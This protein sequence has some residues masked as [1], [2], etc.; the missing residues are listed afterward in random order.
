MSA[1]RGRLPEDKADATY[2]E[3]AKTIA[4][5]E[6]DRARRVLDYFKM[7][8]DKPVPE[9]ESMALAIVERSVILPAST[10]RQLE[11]L[12]EREGQTNWGD[13]ITRLIERSPLVTQGASYLGTEGR[14]F[15]NPAQEELPLDFEQEQEEEADTGPSGQT[16]RPLQLAEG[17]ESVQLKN[18]VIW[19]LKHYGVNA[20]FYTTGYAGKDIN[21]FIEILKAADIS[22]V[23]D[24]RHTPVSQYKPDFSREKLKAHLE[25]NGIEYIHKGD[26]GVPHE[27]RARAV[28]QETRDSIWDWYDQTVVPKISNGA[29]S[30][31]RES[32]KLP[33]AF[34]CVEM[35]PTL[36]H[37]HRL[38]QALKKSGLRGFDL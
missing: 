4:P 17:P 8:P 36:C 10:A 26:W 29:F 34:M 16:Y 3:L 19:N 22:A 37:R 2:T 11:E 6:L 20:D 21:Q 1:V 27:I 31:L 13:A 7:Y 9:I 25:N 14:P 5:L 15:Q 12:V 28:G 33:V 35:D 24:I 23:V 38:S 18:K 30:K 32:V